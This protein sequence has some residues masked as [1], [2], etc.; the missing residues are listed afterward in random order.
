MEKAAAV[1]VAAVQMQQAGTRSKSV[2]AN[3]LKMSGIDAHAVR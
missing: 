2:A 3:L 1:A